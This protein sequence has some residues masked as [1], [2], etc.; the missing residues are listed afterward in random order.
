[1][2]RSR[3][4]AMALLIATVGCKKKEEPR[5]P[6]ATAVPAPPKAQPT[7]TAAT[8]PAAKA[9]EPAPAPVIAYYLTHEV[10]D[11]DLKGKTLRELNL[12]RNVIFA[13]AGNRFRKRWLADYFRKEPW[14][15]PRKKL[16]TSVL[17]PLDRANAKK[18]AH[19]EAK[20]SGDELRRRKSE[21]RARLADGGGTE[22]DGIELGLLS[23]RL[24]VWDS[25]ISGG[26]PTPLQNP[27]LL[28]RLITV[29]ELADFSRRDLRILRNMIFA[30]RGRPFKS[31]ILQEYFAALE[32]YKPDPTYTDARITD[33]D[34]KNVRIIR[35]VEEGLGGML[36]EK[37]HGAENRRG[38]EPS[39]DSEAMEQA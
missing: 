14:Y 26:E 32:W 30:R 2:K 36:T 4:L 8:S 16:D 38:E 13:R 10:T 31:E 25:S 29:R 18:I 23:A 3:I 21:L 5:P 34:K 39:N 22:E 20:L 28:D 33:I 19:Y 17:T 37:E 24:G 7:A 6:A 12:M 27:K 9:P 35:S 1:M 11:A 15:R